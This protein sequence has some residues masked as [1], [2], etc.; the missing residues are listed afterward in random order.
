MFPETCLFSS[1]PAGQ[2]L[3]VLIRLLEIT[4][5]RVEIPLSISSS[6]TGAAS[7]QLSNL[8]SILDSRS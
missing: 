8:E 7:C 1:S 5:I 4:K 3:Q 2:Q 6:T